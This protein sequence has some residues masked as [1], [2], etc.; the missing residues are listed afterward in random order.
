MI[1]RL[2]VMEIDGLSRSI[3]PVSFPISFST[4]TRRPL[5]VASVNAR[6][7]LGARRNRA[8]QDAAED[9]EM[10]ED[11]SAFQ[12]RA[13][14]ELGDRRRAGEVMRLEIGADVVAP[15]PPNRVFVQFELARQALERRAG[16]AQRLDPLPLGMAADLAGPMA[17]GARPSDSPADATRRE[18]GPVHLGV[19]DDSALA[20]SSLLLRIRSSARAAPISVGLSDFFA[21]SNCSTA[22]R[23]AAVR[24]A[25]S[26]IG[27]A[28]LRG[29]PA[30]S[31]FEDRAAAAVAWPGTLAPKSASLEPAA[32][33]RLA[34]RSPEPAAEILAWDLS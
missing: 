27:P 19:R 13:F 16:R 22:R 9:R 12:R 34:G 20:R 14:L 8:H 15:V 1:A 18:Q 7:R 32:L 21:S 23:D 24:A 25:L 30:H 6:V 10:I 11:R 2:L 3:S 26:F 17:S 4:S 29:S 5:N 33:G 31:E 28:G